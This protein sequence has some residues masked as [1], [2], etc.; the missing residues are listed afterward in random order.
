MSEIRAAVYAR[1]SKEQ[2]A[3]EEFKSVTRQ[4]ENAR[5]FA[6]K[7]GW[8]VAEEHIF[9][10]DGVS[11]AEFEGKRLEYTR[12]MGMLRPRAPFQKLIVSERKS[13]GREMAETGMAIKR[14]AQAGV[15]VVEYGHGRSLTPRNATEKVVSAVE[16]FADE[17]HR[18]KTAERMHEAHAR[19]AQKGLV[20]GGRKFGYKNVDVFRGEDEHGRP[21]RSHVDRSVNEEERPAV[22]RAF[23]L[24]D[25]GL[26]LR[27]VA[28]Q[29]NSDGA[30][31]PKP[32]R[33]KP[34]DGGAAPPAGWT[35]ASVRALLRSEIYHGWIVW[36]E[37]RRRDDYGARRPSRR[38]A[39]EVIRVH[40]ED[41][42]I[43][44]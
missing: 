4:V 7:Q 17:A 42:R 12:L 39:K 28:K 13:I 9:I 11:G 35:C 14:L 36:N 40:R 30:A 44:P 27:A 23:Q 5:A 6:T 32:F 19:L 37:S 8:V 20:T 16:G 21:L 2:H 18:E 26:G 1:R 10:D 29:L 15:E 31:A 38:D 25:Q 3:A 22:L 33:R 41:L 43:V 24:H 34:K